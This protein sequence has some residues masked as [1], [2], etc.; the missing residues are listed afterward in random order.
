MIYLANK[1][2]LKYNLFKKQQTCIFSRGVFA[3]CVILLAFYS[4]YTLS[5]NEDIGATRLVTRVLGCSHFWATH[6]YFILPIR[7]FYKF[8]KF[9]ILYYSCNKEHLDIQ[10]RMGVSCDMYRTHEC[11]CFYVFGR[12]AVRERL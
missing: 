9:Y 3:T 11:V 12:A 2:Y 8:Y 10:T 6:G 1:M 7:L 5:I 4:E